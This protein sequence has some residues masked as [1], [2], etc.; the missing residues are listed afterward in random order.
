[1]ARHQLEVMGIR[2]T[3]TTA[4]VLGIDEHPSCGMRRGGADEWHW[5]RWR[6]SCGMIAI[7]TMAPHAGESEMVIGDGGMNHD[8]IYSMRRL[9]NVISSCRSKISVDR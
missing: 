1:M 7:V 8:M 2:W 3:A 5:A 9:T 6:P 4:A